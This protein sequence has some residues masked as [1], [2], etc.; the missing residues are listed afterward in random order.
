MQ[1]AEARYLRLPPPIVDFISLLNLHSAKFK[2]PYSVLHTL[3]LPHHPPPQPSSNPQPEIRR[4]DSA[5][6]RP[7]PTTTASFP[8]ALAA[9]GRQTF[10][11]RSSAVTLG[12]RRGA[13]DWPRNPPW[14]PRSFST[15]IEST[16]SSGGESPLRSPACCPRAYRLLASDSIL[17]NGQHAEICSRR[18][19]VPVCLHQ[20]ACLCQI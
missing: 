5:S 15:R 19:P 10:A 3:P 14:S 12:R 18:F 9:L 17:C 4:A 2:I 11:R 13:R 7:C 1:P 16:F 6:R 8:L 20:N